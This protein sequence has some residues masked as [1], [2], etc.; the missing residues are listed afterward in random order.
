MKE[1]HD[2]VTNTSPC[3]ES[4]SYL[5][6]EQ[7]YIHLGL[8]VCVCVCS[9]CVGRRGYNLCKTALQTVHPVYILDVLAAITRIIFCLIC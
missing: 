9:T 3:S 7:N 2:F 1:E 6:H 8:G 5:Y 4:I